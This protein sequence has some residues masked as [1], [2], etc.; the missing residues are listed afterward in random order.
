MAPSINE[1]AF[2]LVSTWSRIRLGDVIVFHHPSTGRDSVKRVIHISRDGYFVEGD[3]LT[4]STDSRHFGEIP[5]E[6]VIGKAVFQY[7]PRFKWYL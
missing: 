5:K 1:G 6:S 7:S 4:R 3:N 2:L